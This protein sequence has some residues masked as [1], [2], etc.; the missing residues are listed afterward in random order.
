MNLAPDEVLLPERVRIELVIG[1]Q[2]I[3]LVGECHCPCQ[4]VVHRTN[5]DSADIV[6]I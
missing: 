1:C 3:G 4:L 6:V 5:E 2:T